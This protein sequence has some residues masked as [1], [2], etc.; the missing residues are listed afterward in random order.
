MHSSKKLDELKKSLDLDE[1]FFKLPNINPKMY[2][3]DHSSVLSFQ[4]SSVLS[5]DK[6]KYITMNKPNKENR[7]SI[8]FSLQNYQY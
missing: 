8:N 5:L 2:T 6:D 7:N 1:S 4:N 3:P